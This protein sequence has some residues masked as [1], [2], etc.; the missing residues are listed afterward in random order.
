MKYLDVQKLH[1][2]LIRVELHSSFAVD[3][4]EMYSSRM[5]LSMGG[6]TN[7]AWLKEA[8]EELA[9][10]V[11]KAKRALDTVVKELQKGK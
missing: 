6:E 7:R 2:S 11:R 10:H 4:L 5:K 1:G 8:E 9:E 3:A